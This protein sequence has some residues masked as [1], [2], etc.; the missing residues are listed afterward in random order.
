MVGLWTTPSDLAKVLIALQQSFNGARNAFLSQS[1]AKE[2]LTP[3]MNRWGLGVGVGG[4]PARSLL[5]PV[6]EL[7]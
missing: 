1:T 3:V 7:N 5:R 6:K 4:D 2:M